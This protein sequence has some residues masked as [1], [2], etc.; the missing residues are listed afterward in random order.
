MFA[1]HFLLP[2]LM[3]SPIFEDFFPLPQPFGS[4]FLKK[5]S[6]VIELE[7]RPSPLLLDVIDKA[8]LPSHW[9]SSIMILGEFLTHQEI[10]SAKHE[11]L[12]IVMFTLPPT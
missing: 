3:F 4:R 12:D 6:R 11:R 10:D 1:D 2:I 7:M 8:R 9:V 5:F